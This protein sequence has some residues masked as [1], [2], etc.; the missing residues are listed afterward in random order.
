MSS[1]T[2]AS[3]K[4]P[5]PAFL[6]VTAV[7]TG[8][9]VMV[10]EVLGSR[11]IGPFFGVSL[12]VWTALIT[13]TLLALALGYAVG[14]HLADRRPDPAWLYGIILAAGVLVLLVPWLK[15]LVLKATLP[16]GLRAGAFF[17]A[18]L[19]FGPALFLLGC[20]SPYVIRIAAREWGRLGRTVGIFY[21]VSTAGSFAGTLAAGYFVIAYLGIA[22]AF[23]GCGILLI[24]LAAV[25]FAAFRGKWPVLAAPLLAILLLPRAELP[26]ATMPDGTRVRVVFSKDSY[27]GNLKVVDYS[28]GETR[29][30]ELIIDG[31]V[32]GGVDLTSGRSVYEYAYLLELLPLAI[33]PD[34][35]SALVIGLGAGVVPSRF[36]ARGIATDVVDIDPEV[37]AAARD[38]FAFAGADRVF[39]EDARAYLAT[40]DRSYDVIVLDVFNGDTTPAHLLSVEALRQ[41]KSRLNPGGVLAM[42]LM[43]SFG[44]RG[45]MTVSVIK[46]LRAVFGE[47]AVH[48]AY[49][50]EP[51]DRV[52]NYVVLARD[53]PL[54]VGALPDASIHPL[55]EAAVRAGLSRTVAVPDHP[56]AF[57]LT[58]DYNP[59]DVRDLWLKE[60]VRRTILETT[61]PDILLLGA[62]DAAGPAGGGEELRRRIGRTV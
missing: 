46:T 44:E 38:H 36:A 2:Q 23:F 52:G 51:K 33:N 55:V 48:P 54:A 19:L 8:A 27:Y 13:V 6:L 53:G 42:N 41:L 62:L 11:V 21:A 56:G 18:L 57:V 58:D 30:R 22:A 4:A 29:T 49:A 15:P 14:G 45:A 50:D 39:R 16:L 59:I 43:G 28:Y 7:L 9:L 34:S 10:V 1:A 37:V 31:L 60:Q 12:F 5:P 47:V 35:R 32:Q 26:S 25:Y 24:G 17:S 20:V 40:T 61:D 3:P